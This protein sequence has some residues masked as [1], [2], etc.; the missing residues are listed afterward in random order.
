MQQE[1]PTL[2]GEDNGTDQYGQNMTDECISRRGELDAVERKQS[3]GGEINPRF[4]NAQQKKNHGARIAA[5][6]M[7]PPLRRRQISNL[8]IYESELSSVTTGR[9]SVAI[10]QHMVGVNDQI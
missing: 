10:G 2:S 9:S 4:P 5:V 8:R 6:L 1:D 7:G 3:A